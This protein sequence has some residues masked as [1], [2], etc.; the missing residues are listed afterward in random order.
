MM[1]NFAK[2]YQSYLAIKI[3]NDGFSESTI[4][5]TSCIDQLVSLRSPISLLKLILL[6]LILEIVEALLLKFE[7]RGISRVSILAGGYLRRPSVL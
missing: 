6:K 4:E 2:K 1:N 7:S 5:P 3:P